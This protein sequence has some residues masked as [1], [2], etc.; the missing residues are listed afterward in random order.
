MQNHK[1]KAAVCVCAVLNDISDNRSD[2]YEEEW[3]GFWHFYNTM[4]FLSSFAGVTEKGMEAI[5]YN[6]IPV[7]IVDIEDDN[8]D[9]GI[10]EQWTEILEQVFDDDAK[11]YLNK[12]I[13]MGIP[14]PSCVGYE[15]ENSN[16]AVVAE[17]E[18]IWEDK[19]IALLLEEQIK[20][21][22]IF[23]QE[24]WTVIM[25]NDEVERSVFEGGI[26]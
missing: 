21:R 6:T 12:L 14:A 20:D 17:C 2:K 1:T 4:Q 7:M 24:G 18:I 26:N 23:E 11:E 3:N 13:S 10:S 9:I 5:I 16:G 22:E 19:K 25:V 8:A 15:L